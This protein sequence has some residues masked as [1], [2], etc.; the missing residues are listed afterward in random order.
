VAEALTLFY[1]IHGA[2]GLRKKHP[3]CELLDWLKLLMVE[4]IGREVLRERDPKKL[5]PPLH[6]ALIRNEQDVHLFERLAF[7]AKREGRR[8]RTPHLADAKD[9]TSSTSPEPGPGH[10]GRIGPEPEALQ[11]RAN[12]PADREQLFTPVRGLFKRPH[13]GDHLFD[14]LQH[15]IHAHFILIGREQVNSRVELC[16]IEGLG[17]CS[18]QGYRLLFPL[19]FP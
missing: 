17:F 8:G 19:M 7:L 1:E 15:I 3:N 9:P 13:L 11:T 6:G 2:A 12:V 18:L 4:D 10:A 16:E 5:I 14:R